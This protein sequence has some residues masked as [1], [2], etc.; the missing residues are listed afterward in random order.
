L[1]VEIRTNFIKAFFTPAEGKK[2]ALEN[3]YSEQFPTWAK[4]FDKF[5]AHQGAS[6]GSFVLGNKVPLVWSLSGLLLSM[7]SPVC[8]SRTRICS[9]S[10]SWIH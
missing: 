5:I 6:K 7:R 3:F 9:F 10:P 2:A 4:F 1:L 8:R